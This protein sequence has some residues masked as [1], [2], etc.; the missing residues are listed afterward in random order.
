MRGLQKAIEL[1]WYN[2]NKF[3]YKEYEANHKLENGD[4]NWIIPNKII[5]FSSPTDKP[6]DGLPAEYFVPKFKKMGVTG[7]IRLNEPLYDANVFRG[8]GIKVYDLEFLDGSCPADDV[9]SAFL[10]MCEQQLNYGGA[11]AVHCRAG[12]GR[13]GT[14]IA[15]YIMKRYHFEARALLGW[16]RI[17]RP[18]M[19]I[20]Q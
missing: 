12:L 6:K 20:G 2:F 9:I 10:G 1:G 3:D 4:M 16:L 15:C 11:I 8:E 5:A 7:V 13:T 17:A 14:L 19:V 18:G